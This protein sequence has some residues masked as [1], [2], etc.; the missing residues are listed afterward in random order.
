MLGE[1]I[2]LPGTEVPGKL[3]EAGYARTVRALPGSASA[4]VISAEPVGA[5]T[6]AVV[7]PAKAYDR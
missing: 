2:K 4:P 5:Q 7:A 3:V 1:I 6:R